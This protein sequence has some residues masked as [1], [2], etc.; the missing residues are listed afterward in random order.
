MKVL[1][2]NYSKSFTA[3]QRIQIQ[4][5]VDINN[6][7]NI[8]FYWH[9]EVWHF[10]QP[11]NEYENRIPYFFRNYLLR[12]LLFWI[13]LIKRSRKYDYI[14]HRHVP[15]DIFAI[16]FARIVNNRI[17]IHHGKEL[18]ELKLV[19]QG[20]SSLI[21]T[22][23]EK[24]VGKYSLKYCKAIVGVTPEIANYELL[25]VGRKLPVFTYPNSI[26][27]DPTKILYDR[28]SPENLNA[29]F[30]CSTFNPWH[31]LDRL[32]KSI[33]E[34][35]DKILAIKVNI[36]LVG[37][38]SNQQR[39][40]VKSTV[41]NKIKIYICGFV[42]QKKLDKILEKMD[43]GIGSLAMDRQ[44]L[45][46]GSVLKVRQYLDNGLPVLCGYKEPSFLEKP[47]IVRTVKQNY[48]D[49]VIRFCTR[50]KQF[51]KSKVR[52]E[53]KEL[54]DKKLYMK[55]LVDFMNTLKQD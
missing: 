12:S 19:S 31:G 23:V 3:G 18:E 8:G 46:E 5:E 10:Q 32:I 38:L 40:Y 41:K 36:Y 24:Y 35:D 34:Y 21:A 15:F 45:Q 33:Q 37:K 52:A 16:F 27:Y 48:I 43:C 29:I 49:E 50:A 11:M 47:H 42:K 39:N 22:T 7:N 44:N 13:I 2:L 6:G 25:R 17:T 26:V 28:R 20:V 4:A 54:L 1:N 51:K 14:I 53:A 9:N 30:C 55:N